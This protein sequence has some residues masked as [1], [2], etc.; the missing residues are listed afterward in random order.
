MYDKTMTTLVF[1]SK[2]KKEERSLKLSDLR[3]A[4]HL[5]ST[6]DAA[7]SLYYVMERAIRL[8]T[9]RYSNHEK[10][11]MECGYAISYKSS[12]GGGTIASTTPEEQSQFLE[13]TFAWAEALSPRELR[14]SLCSMGS[15]HQG[16]RLAR[17]VKGDE[18]IE[19]L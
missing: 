5:Y 11:L 16:L 2:L 13:A 18:S 14:K 4:Q 3:E 10:S 8:L 9:L 19:V 15:F 6:A 1:Q 12:E 17:I 7:D